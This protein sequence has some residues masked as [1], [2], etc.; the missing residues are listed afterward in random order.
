VLGTPSAETVRLAELIRQRGATVSHFVGHLTYGDAVSFDAH[1]KWRTLRDLGVAGELYCGVPDDHY[2]RIS[3]PLSAH[4]PARDELI[5]FHYSVWSE[6][7]AYARSL[8][9]TPVL[10]VYHN[11]TPTK[12]FEGVHKQ[13]E[14]DTRLGRE[15]LPSFVEQCPYA[16]AM[17]EYSRQ[18]LEQVGFRST[19]VVP[20][21]SDFS[22]LDR[23]TKR[24]ERELDDGYINIF[25][26]SRIAPNKC[27]EDTIKL[28]YHYK[29]QINPRARLV[30]VG[31]N[32]VGSYRVWLERLV[33]R[34]GLDPHVIFAGHVS[35]EDL[36]AYHRSA[37]VYVSMSEH[38]GFSA[39]LLASMYVGVPVMGFDATA[40]PYT[41]GDA[42]VLLRRK[43][44][45]VAAEALDLLIRPDSPLR[46]R[47]VA[48]GQEWVRDFFPDRV[49]ERFV[50][51]V[52][53]A[54][55]IG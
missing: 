12:W 46:A 11:V 53:R 7:A 44:H 29:R 40:T 6:A 2:R 42:G 9:S 18:E 41:M 24:I 31:A 5:V 17:S 55:E 23:P 13:A 54:L 47:M 16:V 25:S 39:S 21:M 15:R 26:V 45:A 28:F 38:E 4:R 8:A 49:G 50:G 35:N 20:L 19:G 52:A 43:D 30:I 14:E 10:F 34:L 22:Y 27:H 1:N 51:A 48:R 33:R 37:H 3:L 32:V 36:A